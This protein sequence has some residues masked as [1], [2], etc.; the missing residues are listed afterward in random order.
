M[1]GVA[2][3]RAVMGNGLSELVYDT[4]KVIWVGS[5]NPRCERGFSGPDYACTILKEFFLF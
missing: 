2:P 4:E 5:A 1:D 3:E